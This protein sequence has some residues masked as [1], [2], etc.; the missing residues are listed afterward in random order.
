LTRQA[1]SIEQWAV[2]LVCAIALLFAGFAHQVPVIEK[3]GIK[4]DVAEY[5]LPDGTLPI[6]CITDNSDPAQNHKMRMEGCQACH[7]NASIVLPTPADVQG[8]ALSFVT[9][10]TAPAWPTIFIRPLFPPNRGPRAPPASD[11]TV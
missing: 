2:R 3:D 10:V 4:I 9:A 6:F 1:T 8:S 7:I 11:P 5:V